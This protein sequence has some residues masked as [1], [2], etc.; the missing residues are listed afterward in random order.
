MVTGKG[1]NDF[2]TEL[3]NSAECVPASVD[4]FEF[5]AIKASWFLVLINIK[6]DIDKQ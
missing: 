4:A 5:H 6:Y 3:R 1:T 2:D